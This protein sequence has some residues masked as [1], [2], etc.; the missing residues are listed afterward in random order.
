MRG[1]VN[2]RVVLPTTQPPSAVLDPRI[3]ATRDVYGRRIAEQHR[4]A[5]NERTSAFTPVVTSRSAAQVEK[6]PAMQELRAQLADATQAYE[7]AQRRAIQHHHAGEY[8]KALVQVR[9]S[10]IYARTRKVIENELLKITE[11]LAT[12]S[13][14][15]IMKATSTVQ[16]KL[17]KLIPNKSSVLARVRRYQTSSL[18]AHADTMDVMND[19]MDATALDL[20]TEED[21]A[22]YL[23]VVGQAR[24]MD[25]GAVCT[26]SPH[27]PRPVPMPLPAVTDMREEDRLDIS[28]MPV[29]PQTMPG[30]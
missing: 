21:D 13:R 25:P 12:A 5:V 29:P 18:D 10:K 14:A 9:V 1:R 26:A 28:N 24:P 16:A 19:A 7:E 15:D 3:D 2:I 27:I 20:D 30:T 11:S 23:A 22:A 17:R 6:T 4:I 8:D